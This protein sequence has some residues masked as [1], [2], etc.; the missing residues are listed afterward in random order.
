[1]SDKTRFLLIMSTGFAI[2]EIGLWAFGASDGMRA[3]KTW[4]DMSIGAL[5]FRML[6]QESK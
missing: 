2:A 4:L 3:I 6:Y 5:A 1:M